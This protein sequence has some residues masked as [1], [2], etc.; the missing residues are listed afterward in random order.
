MQK[1]RSPWLVCILLAMTNAC[2]P[3]I[4][5]A[6][7][8]KN[9]EGEPL[10]GARVAITCDEKTRF[11]VEEKEVISNKNGQFV[12]TG[13]GCLPRSCKIS[14]VWRNFSAQRS[15]GETCR[16]TRFACRADSS[17]NEA[18]VSLLVHTH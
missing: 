7:V 2:D 16:K 15:I 1:R 10:I 9:N 18:Q 4:Q 14:A 8:V 12:F 3:E 5:V 6:G 11:L 13:L 17:C